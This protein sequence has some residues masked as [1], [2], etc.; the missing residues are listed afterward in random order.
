MPSRYLDAAL[1]DTATWPHWKPI[2]LERSPAETGCAV[3]DISE[4]VT[5]TQLAYILGVTKPR[6]IQI[7]RE[8]GIK[9][10]LIGNQVFYHRDQ[11]PLFA[12]RNREESSKD[13]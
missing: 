1:L 4:Y 12:P 7:E 10:K 8:R 13:A 5:R 6:I 9:G 3:A 11:L 2:G